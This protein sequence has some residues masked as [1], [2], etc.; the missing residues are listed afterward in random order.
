[1]RIANGRTARE[2]E[3]VT[4]ASATGDSDRGLVLLLRERRQDGR[5]ACDQIMGHLRW[6]AGWVVST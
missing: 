4:V 1:M 5:V 6:S 2:R 3:C